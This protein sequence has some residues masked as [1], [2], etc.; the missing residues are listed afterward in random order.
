LIDTN[1]EAC[2]QAQQE[3]LPVFVNSALDVEV[4]E[5]AGINAAATLL[6]ITNNGDVNA[7]IAQ[8]AQEEFQLPRV[9]SV[10]PKDDAANEAVAKAKKAAK[11]S[12]AGA[13]TNSVRAAFPTIALKL[14]NTHL[15]EGAVRL[16]ET[17]L[18]AEGAMMQRAH[19]R[20]LMRSGE[21]IPL[22]VKRNERM[23]V[24][25]REEDDWKVGDRIVYLLHDPK[26]KLLQRLSG[27]SRP[28]RLNV[29]TLPAVEEVPLPSKVV[30][31]PPPTPELAGTVSDGTTVN[32]ASAPGTAP[33][34][35][36]SASADVV[37]D[38]PPPTPKTP[39]SETSD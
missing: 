25:L 39:A 32:G 19:L 34:S 10:V 29:E 35:G 22:L 6:A 18:R 14:W 21:L 26:P 17:S 36:Q 38:L 5:E 24:S 7:V 8:Q 3:N 15:R 11:K 27:G 13:K 9:V 31:P 16:G 12:N 23:W 30:E 20:A 37:D 1:A 28:T 4:L 33:P 2:E